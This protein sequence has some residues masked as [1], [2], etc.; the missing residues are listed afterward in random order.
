[1]ASPYDKEEKHLKGLYEKIVNNT[2]ELNAAAAHLRQT[3]SFAELK[4]L[5]GEWLVPEED[6]EAFIAGRRYFL[7][8]VAIGEK[9]YKKAEDKLREEMWALNDKHFTDVVAF[10]LLRRCEASEDLN[11]YVLRKH[12]TLQKCMNYIMEQAFH[13]ANEA[14]EE[15]KKEG[16]P[17]MPMGMAVEG[18]KVI[19]WAEAYYALE[20]EEEET[21]KKDEEKG[22]RRK[23]NEEQENLEKQ[24]PKAL[25]KKL[26]EKKPEDQQMSLFNFMQDGQE[27]KEA[28]NESV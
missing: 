21:K 4:R 19:S 5:A 23:K 8:D 16:P 28:G 14:Y 10:H 6:V 25:T 13:E 26:V 15:S 11:E 3:K 9:E 24:A 2:G 7:A 27:S 12:K 20:D 1:M 18:N 22:R 17:D